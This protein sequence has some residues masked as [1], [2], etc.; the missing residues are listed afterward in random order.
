MGSSLFIH[1]FSKYLLSVY[2][3][4]AAVLTTEGVAVSKSVKGPALME[5][6]ASQVSSSSFPQMLKEL[7]KEV[8][9]T[10]LRS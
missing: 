3:V 10:A 7:S 5:L 6:T 9:C 1:S 4:P 8:K 2:C